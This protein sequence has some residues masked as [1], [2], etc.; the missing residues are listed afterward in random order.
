MNDVMS[1]LQPYEAKLAF[2]RDIWLQKL[3][4][5]SLFACFCSLF[6]QKEIEKWFCLQ[7]NDMK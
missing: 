4:F 5:S 6:C 2:F 3:N 7:Q 1:Y